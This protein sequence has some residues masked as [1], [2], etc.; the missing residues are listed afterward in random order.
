[1][2][3]FLVGFS[4]VSFLFFGTGCLASRRMAREFERYGLARYR[5]TTGLLQLAG[6]GGL[7]LGFVAPVSGFFAAGGLAVQMLLGV[8]VRLKIRD[9][10][11]QATPALLYC[12]INAYLCLRFWERI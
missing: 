10:L 7:A 11:F 12:F 5:K 2:F 1:M 9:S 6:A 4:A 8:G 3:P